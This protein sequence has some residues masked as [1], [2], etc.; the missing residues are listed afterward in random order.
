MT[1][2]EAGLRWVRPPQQA[3][4]QETLDR[5]LDAAEQ[6]VTEK[7]FDD[8]PVAEVARRADSSVGAFY[9]RF[10]DKDGLLHALY[11]RWLVEATATADAALDAARWEGA[12]VSEIIATVVRFLVEIYRERGGL[13]RAF[14][15]RNHVDPDFHARQERLSHYISD[16]LCALLMAR[17]DEIDRPDPERASAFGLTLLFSTLESVML[18]GEYRSGALALSDDDL[19]RELTSAYLAYLGVPH[20]STK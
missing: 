7:G 14:V 4:S 9:S 16:R 8:T 5:L 20:R 19:G 13:I 18:F 15:L 10:R 12:S 1:P 17:R 6:L 2:T 11:E 3:R